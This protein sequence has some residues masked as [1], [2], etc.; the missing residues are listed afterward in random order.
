MISVALCTYNGDQFLEEQLESILRQTVLPDEIVLG[1]DG[2]QDFTLEIAE[3]YIPIFFKFGVQFTLMKNTGISNFV[4]N[5]ERTLNATQ[6]DY[7]FLSDQDD[8][9]ETNRIER[10]ME[11]FSSQPRCLLVHG[12]ARLINSTGK[13]LSRSMFQQL[14]YTK[15]LQQRAI[16]GDALNQL[17]QRNVV[18]GATTAIRRELLKLSSPFVDTWIHD[19]WLA[20]NSAAKGGYF[21]IDQPLIGYR[22]HSNNVVGVKP[23]SLRSVVGY[24][25]A[26]RRGRHFQL[27]ER[28]ESLLTHAQNQAWDDALIHLIRSKYEFEQKRLAFPDSRWG[29]I[30]EILKLILNGDYDQFCFRPIRESFRD[31][32]QAK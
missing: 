20:I 15:R 12:D 18:T 8:T 9:W 31:L 19:E 1:D 28:C 13:D 27:V 4:R 26:S 25:F 21:V 17:L 14:G 30:P 22:Q 24:Y 11:V 7:I 3:R 10:S 2:S 23:R 29:R 16:H 5:F 32:S 6:G